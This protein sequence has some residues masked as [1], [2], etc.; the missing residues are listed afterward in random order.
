ML[1]S[2][3]DVILHTQVERLLNKLLGDLVSRADCWPNDVER[4]LNSIANYKLDVLMPEV[5]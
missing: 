5:S 4:S 3:V 2:Q 1:H